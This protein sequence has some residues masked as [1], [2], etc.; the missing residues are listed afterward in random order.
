VKRHDLVPFRAGGSL[1]HSSTE[2]AR[3]R[4]GA[5]IRARC[6]VRSGSCQRAASP[7]CSRASSSKLALRVRPTRR[8]RLP[9][10]ARRGPRPAMPGRAGMK[11]ARRSLQVHT[12]SPERPANQWHVVSPYQPRWNE[13]ESARRVPLQAKIS[14]TGAAQSSRG[15]SASGGAVKPARVRAQASNGACS[16]ARAKGAGHAQRY[17]PW[18][19]ADQGGGGAT[20]TWGGGPACGA[21]AQ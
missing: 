19:R 8:A 2:R 7:R 6:P 5:Q 4:P 21:N 11:S 17:R 1:E 14:L 12:G 16:S 9:C 3:A 10:T 13:N 20:K 15:A 18:W